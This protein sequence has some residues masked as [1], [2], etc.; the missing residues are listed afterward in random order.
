[1]LLQ[2]SSTIFG[3]HRRIVIDQ[4]RDKLLQLYDVEQR[5]K[6]NEELRDDV[7]ARVSAEIYSELGDDAFDMIFVGKIRK[8]GNAAAHR[9][10]KED[11]SRSILDATLGDA[12]R[13]CLTKI[14]KFTNNE[15]PALNDPALPPTSA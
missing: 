10:G 15:E 9:A 8:R 4:A 3:L 1:L 14:C 12:E 11:L 13:V 6:S 7:K 5:S 2:Q